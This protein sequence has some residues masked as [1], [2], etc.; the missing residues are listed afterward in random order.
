MVKISK[1]FAGS[2]GDLL[3]EGR[4]FHGVSV[5]SPLNEL[6]DHGE[7]GGLAAGAFGDQ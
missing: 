1:G 7:R 4:Q 5:L 6:E 3:A 2:C